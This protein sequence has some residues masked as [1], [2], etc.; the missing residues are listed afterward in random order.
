MSRTVARPVSGS[1]HGD[2]ASRALLIPMI[3]IP[4]PRAQTGLGRDELVEQRRV[5]GGRP[6]KLQDHVSGPAGVRRLTLVILAGGLRESALKRTGVG[7]ELG[8]K[9]SGMRAR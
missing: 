7:Q 1:P 9:C 4:R 3:Q 8:G 2:D 6:S 5:V